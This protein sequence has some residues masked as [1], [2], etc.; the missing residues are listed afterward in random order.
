MLIV[1]SP[2]KRLDFESAPHIVAHT[3]PRFLSQARP[4]VG[5]L[6]KMDTRELASLMSISDPLA[7]LNAARFG[8]WKPPFTS[9]NARQAVLAFAGD[10]YEGLDAS[11][12][13]ESDLGWAQEHVRILS[14]LYGVL[15]PLDLIQ[16]YRLEMGTRLRNPKGDDL[17]S[18]WG[19]RLSKAIDEELASHR[20]PVLVNLAPPNAYYLSMLAHW[21]GEWANFHGLL[22]ALAALWPFA[23][24]AWWG[25]RMHARRW[26]K[27]RPPIIE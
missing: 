15:R 4:L 25:R 20:V 11:S 22:R 6:K 18:Y 10:V 8:Q 3:Q 17:Y 7:A 5:L 12:L 1:L 27:E 21:E 23:A 13:D 16:A 9:R 24:L 26:R 14:G 2:A 19:E